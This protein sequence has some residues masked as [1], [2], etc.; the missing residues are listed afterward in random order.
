M[1]EGPSEEEN[2]ST[3]VGTAP[4]ER[5]SNSFRHLHSELADNP[6]GAKFHQGAPALSIRR[7][8]FYVQPLSS[9]S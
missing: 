1:A 7:D 6:Q 9:S 5:Y 8:L 2:P 3:A 4:P